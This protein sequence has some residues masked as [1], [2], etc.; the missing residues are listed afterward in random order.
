M[1]KCKKANK[2]VTMLARGK[3]SI[4]TTIDRQRTCKSGYTCSASRA[5]NAQAAS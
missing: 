4:A 2:T 3:P 5:N 1:I